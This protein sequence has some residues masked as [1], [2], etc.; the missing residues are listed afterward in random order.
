M[1]AIDFF[2]MCSET[3]AMQRCYLGVQLSIQAKHYPAV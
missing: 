2:F 1:T 3:L